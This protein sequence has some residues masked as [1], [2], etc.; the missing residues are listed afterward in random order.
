MR[1]LLL[2]DSISITVLFLLY[3]CTNKIDHSPLLDTW[4][5][6]NKQSRS[7]SLAYAHIC[8]LSTKTV[9]KSPKDRGDSQMKA[10]FLATL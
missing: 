6:T 9:S 8:L 10:F 4:K 2:V 3:V 5:Q 1:G 7:P